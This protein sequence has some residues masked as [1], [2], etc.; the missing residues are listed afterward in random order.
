MAEKT[1][2]V[3]V[4]RAPLLAVPSR[5]ALLESQALS[6]ETF[7]VQYSTK[8]GLVYARSLRDGCEG[9]IGREALIPTDH[10]P[11]LTHRVRVPQTIARREPVHK[12]SS[13]MTLDLNALCAVTEERD[14]FTHI[15]GAGWVF[16]A[17][18]MPI[19]GH[20]SF[21]VGVA[22]N[23]IGAPYLWGG[24]T[25][26]GID[27]SGVVQAAL[28]AGGFKCPR[29]S[30]DIEK[31]IGKRVSR[32]GGLT[33]GDLVFWKGHVGIMTG[34]VNVLHATTHSMRVVVE[35]LQTVIDRREELGQ[36]KITSIR[37]L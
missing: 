29:N 14:G 23:F 32:K 8:G 12:L 7:A 26:S 34:S 25:I 11:P 6:G 30:G 21:W 15:E 17:D 1:M 24:R 9:Y 19:D 5:T 20:T 36:G 33:C 27:C 37:R 22:E 18:L 35:S 13:V 2:R 3:R 28:I 10:L 16:A 4:A 31:S